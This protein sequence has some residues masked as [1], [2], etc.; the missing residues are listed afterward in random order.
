MTFV[1]IDDLPAADPTASELGMVQS[2]IVSL[3]TTQA[4]ISWLRAHEATLY[5]ALVEMVEPTTLRFMPMGDPP[6]F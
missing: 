1:D 2:L 5:T 6:P 4:Q 3:Q